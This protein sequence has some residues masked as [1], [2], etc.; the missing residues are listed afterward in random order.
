MPLDSPQKNPSNG[1]T[2]RLRKTLECR[3]GNEPASLQTFVAAY[4]AAGY[5]GHIEVSQ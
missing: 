4:S 1:V 3:A 2:K 5:V